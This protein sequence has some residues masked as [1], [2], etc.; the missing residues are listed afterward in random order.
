V[1]GVG[2]TTA[3]VARGSP[4]EGRQWHNSGGLATGGGRRG[5][6]SSI[7]VAEPAWRGRRTQ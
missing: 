1:V 7:G 2:G 5:L 3:A 4:E 6:A